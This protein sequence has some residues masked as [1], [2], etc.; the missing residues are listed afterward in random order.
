MG[1]TGTPAAPSWLDRIA[2]PMPSLLGS[3]GSLYAGIYKYNRPNINYDIL[4]LRAD[5]KDIQAEQQLARMEQEANILRKQFNQAAG[6]HTYG[7]V[8]RNVKAGEG[9]A[10]QNLEMSARDMGEDIYTM[11]RNADFQAR[12]LR[13]EA[14]MLRQGADDLQE[15]NKW[16]RL[17]GLFAGISDAATQFG[18]GWD[19][20]DSQN[21]Q[22]AAAQEYEA[23][24]AAKAAQ[25]TAPAAATQ[26]ITPDNTE[27]ERERI[28][29]K[30]I[31]SNPNYNPNPGGFE[32]K[33][34]TNNP[35]A[36]TISPMGEKQ[37]TETVRTE[38]YELERK[39]RLHTLDETGTNRLK[40]VEKELADRGVPVVK[41]G[42]DIPM[43]KPQKTRMEINY[44]KV[45]KKLADKEKEFE[46]IKLKFAE[47]ESYDTKRYFSAENQVIRNK[48]YDLRHEIEKLKRKQ[49]F[50][51]E[52]GLKNL[53]G[54][55]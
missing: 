50:Y 45:T 28:R 7:A 30:L 3:A 19:I 1:E 47:I 8:R 41:M 23:A 35:Y 38:Y 16:E 54:R 20:I 10:A 34:T 53:Q 48:Y 15:V 11:R 51:G 44:E 27:K 33:A 31:A 2:K 37:I 12:Q 18:I 29:Q 49:K 32:L 39:Q 9:G 5:Y 24:Q 42:Q 17:G 43:P 25:A 52:S 13:G 46:E 21:K 22:A 14:E 6:S 40:E 26:S 55:K 36:E 4:N